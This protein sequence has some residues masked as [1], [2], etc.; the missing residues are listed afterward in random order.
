[1]NEILAFL[2][3]HWILSSAFVVVLVIF[4]VNELLQERLGLQKI[5]PEEVIQIMNHES[6][7][8]IDIRNV[9]SFAEGYILGSQN[10]PSDQLASKLNTIQK[11]KDKTIVVVCAM[12]QE[13]QKAG[14][15]LKKA[16]FNV[17]ILKQGI[18]GWKASGLPVV[19]K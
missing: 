13:A 17:K 12:G 19:K 7:V 3:N 18:Q 16:G 4:L 11:W 8:V 14:D 1:M 9:K 10:L 15:K 6:G 2:S 5:S